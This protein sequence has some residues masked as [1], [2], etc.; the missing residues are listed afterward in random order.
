MLNGVA[1]GVTHTAWAE[2]DEGGGYQ[3]GGDVSTGIPNFDPNNYSSMDYGFG[4]NLG[5][6]TGTQYY[7]ARDVFKSP[8]L[9]GYTNME[10]TVFSR[11]A[12]PVVLEDANRAGQFLVQ[13]GTFRFSTLGNESYAFVINEYDNAYVTH[14]NFELT[15]RLRCGVTYLGSGVDADTPVLG[16]PY[17]FIG[18]T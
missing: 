16:R 1:Y 13:N 4:A 18:R 9:L 5:A 6:I 14:E 17:N 15:Y 8:I 3:T 2:A 10:A 12:A 11:H 7:A